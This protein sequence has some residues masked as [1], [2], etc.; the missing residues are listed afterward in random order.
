[1]SNFHKISFFLTQE[2]KHKKT[3]EED[4]YHLERFEKKVYNVL[5][6][7]VINAHL[8]INAAT[9]I[10]HTEH[11]SSFIVIVVPN[12]NHTSTANGKNSPG[13][14]ELVI[15][16]STTMLLNMYP[17]IMFTYSGYMLTHRQQLSRNLNESDEFVNIV[18]YNSKR[19]FCN[20]MES[21][22]CDIKEDKKN[23]IRK[24][25]YSIN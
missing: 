7:S 14:F 15:N 17:G 2:T 24:N 10:E 25:L 1:M 5:E 18:T 21:F 11:D 12:Q 13:R 19:F 3:S 16:E 6:L 8:R 22:R 20:I 4:I 23:N 9:K